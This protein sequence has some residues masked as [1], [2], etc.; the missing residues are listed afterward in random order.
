MYPV[1]QYSSKGFAS[2]IRVMEKSRAAELADRV[3]V[4][5][6]TDPNKKRAFKHK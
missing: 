3:Q 1:D 4:L 2:P 6:K 5:R